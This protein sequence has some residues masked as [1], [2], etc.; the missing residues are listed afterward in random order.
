MIVENWG[1]IEYSNAWDIQ[2][3]YQ[4]EVLQG[5]RDSTFVTCQHPSVITIGRAAGEANLVAE[6][7]MLQSL[8]IDVIEVNRGGDIT[9]HNPNQLVGYFIFDLQKLKP[10]LHWFLREIEEVIIQS[11]KEFD[12]TGKR[13][14]EFTGVWVNSQ[15]QEKKICAIGVNCARWVTSHG[16][17]LNVSNDLSEFNY[18]VPCGISDRKVTSIEEQTFALPDF[19]KVQQVVVEKT[20]EVFSF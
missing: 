19:Q 1:L 2:K 9:L 16:F 3:R 7:S 17:A 15:S 12:I 11:L 8:K 13:V 14:D 6:K 18:I 4:S 10:D 5:N 20:L